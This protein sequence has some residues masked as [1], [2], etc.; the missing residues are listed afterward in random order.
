M[1]TIPVIALTLLTLPVAAETTVVCPHDYS[2]KLVS[3]RPPPGWKGVAHAPDQWAKL[4]S[5]GVVAG[6]PFRWA[7]AAQMGEET[8]TPHGIL[9]K[10]H[11][12]NAFLEPQSK[13]VYC[14]YGTDI[15]MQL[16]QE[17]PNTVD[18]CV[19]DVRKDRETVT[20]ITVKCR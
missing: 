9:I 3:A 17:V 12:L 10:F 16:L 11:D 19:A 8:R 18:T 1:K 6:S 13:W 14:Q 5:A 20:E 7:Q 4:T 15:R 2:V